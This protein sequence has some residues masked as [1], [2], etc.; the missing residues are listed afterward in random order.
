MSR[1]L[2]STDF[3]PAGFKWLTLKRLKVRWCACVFSEL[4]RKPFR[5]L[6]ACMQYQDPNGRYHE[7]WAAS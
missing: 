7:I 4:V 1:L 3:G 6:S 5:Q 2:E